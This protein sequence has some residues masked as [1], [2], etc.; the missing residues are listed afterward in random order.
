ME[1]RNQYPGLH[2]YAVRTVRHH[3]MRLTRS[4]RFSPADL[5]DIEQELM[6][7]LHRRL[8]RFDAAK[9][10]VTTF[11]A[12][13]VANHAAS[14]CEETR[15]ERHGGIVTLSLNEV[16]PDGDEDPME[17]IDTITENQSPWHAQTLPW[18]EAI[19]LRRDILL[20][21]RRLPPSL[22]HIAERLMEKTVA[23][24]AASAGIPRQ[25]LYEAIGR[26]RIRL[27][28]ADHGKKSPTDSK[29]RRYVR[30]ME[31][32]MTAPA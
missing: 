9:A 10:D 24:L 19:E 27:S 23:E 26:I 4:A 31:H 3:A 30:G 29:I 6:L 25:K 2:P 8:S 7:D 21:L 15:W 16:I 28:Q 5:E 14:L 22:R 11:I 12:R 20:L 1:S 13:V 17:R 32:W 18:N